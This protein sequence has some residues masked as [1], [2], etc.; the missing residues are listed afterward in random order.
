MLI[1]II[2]CSIVLVLL[3]ALI[4]AS[5]FVYHRSAMSTVV[6][7]YLR[8]TEKHYT[9]AELNEAFKERM[10]KGD[11]P[12]KKPKALSCVEK[13]YQGMQT[14]YVNEA[15]GSE[16]AVIYL[17]GGAYYRKP[18]K[19]HFRFIKKISKECN[20]PFIVPIYK[21]A[22]NHTCKEAYDLLTAFYKEMKSQYKS[23]ILM[24]DS[25]GGGLALGL[26]LHLK[27]QKIELPSSLVLLSPWVD[28]ALGNSDIESYIK[29]DP[30]VFLDNVKLLGKAWAG[31]L[32]LDDYRVSPINGE[33]EGLPTTHI[34]C[35]TRELL[36]PDSSLLYEKIKNSG[37]SVNFHI[38][39]GQN[40]VYPIFPLI[41]E[42]KEAQKVIKSTINEI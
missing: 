34:F 16:K 19:H 23:V 36:Y 41:K 40:H 8:L 7:W 15:I 3:L 10:E 6:E 32:S 13:E 37:V 22:P 26:T 30:L 42:A 14:F 17:H 9:E 21:K 2:I 38:G 25:S 12:C 35:G 5:K 24:G 27:N 20:I 31:E 4:I 1:G 28:V 18:R 11:A 39:E 33:M 29:K